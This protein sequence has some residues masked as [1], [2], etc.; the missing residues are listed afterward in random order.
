MFDTRFVFFALLLTAAPLRAAVA[1][2][3]TN[4]GVQIFRERCAA[5]HGERGEGTDAAPAALVGDKSVA[6]LTQLISE[7]MPE[8]DPEA[9]VGEDAAQVAAYIHETFYSP[10]A[11]ARNKPARVALSR[12]TVRQYHN[13]VADLIGSFRSPGEWDAERGL[14][15]EYY[16][17][18]RTRRD[19]RV[20]E[21]RDATIDFHFGEES[22]AEKI[23]K[24]EFSMKWEG[25]VLAPDTG[26][27]EIIVDTENAFRLWLNNDNQ[28]L[29]DA[30]VRSGDGTEF[31]EPIHLL[32]GRVYPIRLEYFK[33]KQE[34]T[35]SIV[36]KWKTPH[37]VAEVI[38][39]RLLS[40]H[41]FPELLALQT[42][43]PPDDRSVG[44]ERGASVSKA[45]TQATTYAAIEV[46][47]Y[48]AANLDELADARGDASDREARVR[49]FAH[50]FVEHAFRRPLTDEQ[51]RFFVDQ[52]FE[53]MSDPSAAI[54]RVVLLAL[55][56]PRFLYREIGEE[57]AYAVASRL[58][59]GLWDSLP[60]KALL[61]AAAKGELAT[62]E[63][64][65]EQAQRMRP[66]LRTRFKLR[67][68]LHQWLRV[69]HIPDLAKDKEKYPD[70]DE[71]IIADLR[72][73]LELF[74]EDAVWGESPDFR[75]LLL[76]DYLYVNGRL[77]KFYGFDL[78]EEA[79]FQKVAV[80]PQQRAG[81]LSHPFLLAGFAYHA[82][83]S[84]IHR[85]VFVSR[86]LL[87]RTLKPPPEAVSPLSPGLHA[88]LTTRERV[89]LQTGANACQTCHAM[90][91]PLG[92]SLENFDA[93]GR[94]RTEEQGK[95][96]DAAGAY[97][98]TSGEEVEFEGVRE[99]ATFLAA[100]EE[101]HGAFVQ[102]LFHHL[103]KQP[104]LA[105][106]ADQGEELRRAFIAGGYNVQQ[107][108]AEAVAAAAIKQ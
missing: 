91:N 58:S 31:K 11:Q 64:A 98:T 88:D 108:A 105:Y 82:T 38:P 5:C 30:W 92:F 8:D 45:W 46:A 66:D 35:A 97:T 87:G 90:I 23:G 96:I 62:R 81:V 4:A 76:A 9:C 40:P 71:Q 26:E 103:V 21:R 78:P 47:G 67:E 89:I 3:E 1:E 57:D 13:A 56:S 77:A 55:K 65:L 63:Q 24:E 53:G 72:T 29:I 19:R 51:R 94:Y 37:G 6:E 28:P 70:F 39:E 33:S 43:F 102:Q 16:N 59:F 74:L 25:A 49:D 79:P 20:L 42:P 32:G 80:D 68:F 95:P 106:G 99:L 15:G 93:V 14:K 12:L 27:Y 83:S 52:H 17:D 54:K 22:P 50:R 104:I 86:S 61:E 2:E 41:R 7:T 73:S 10:M 101:S 100:S 18:R 60:D 85:G 75:Q 69:D 48:V 107:L 36:L 34:K 44:Y 84:P